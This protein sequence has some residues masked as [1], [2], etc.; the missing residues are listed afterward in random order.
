MIN[1]LV[2]FNNYN[3]IDPVEMRSIF[4]SEKFCS[5]LVHLSFSCCLD[6]PNSNSL[7]LGNALIAQKKG[8]KKKKRH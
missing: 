7:Q 2:V 4:K 1:V 6:W 3:G 5:L 8:R